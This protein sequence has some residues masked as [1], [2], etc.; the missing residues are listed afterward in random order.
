M[1][2]LLNKRNI[3]FII[4]SL[5]NQGK[6]FVLLLVYLFILTYNLNSQTYTNFYL[7]HVG[8]FTFVKNG[9][10]FKIEAIKQTHQSNY[11]DSPNYLFDN[12]STISDTNFNQ[13]LYTSANRVYSKVN[14]LVNDSELINDEVGGYDSLGRIIK[15]KTGINTLRHLYVKRPGTLNQYLLFYINPDNNLLNYCLIQY[16]VV[17]DTYTMVEKNKELDKVFTYSFDITHH[18]N[19]KDLWIVRSCNNNLYVSSLITENEIGKI[20]TFSSLGSD[21]V[22]RTLEYYNLYYLNYTKI[23]PDGKYLAF[24]TNSDIDLKNPNNR[25]NNPKFNPTIAN[26]DN[27]TGKVSNKVLLEYYYD[28]LDYDILNDV[29]DIEFSAKSH[30]FFII[31]KDFIYKY[32]YD[33]VKQGYIKDIYKFDFLRSHGTKYL[34]SFLGPDKNIYFISHN[35]IFEI[36][37]KIGVKNCELFTIKGDYNY[38]QSNK[39]NKSNLTNVIY[40]TNLY[41][42]HPF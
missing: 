21:D 40:E 3:I 9:N 6:H 15:Y 11:S 24:V 13:L 38:K 34:A 25:P 29:V 20:N 37:S 14:R 35:S 26:F 2:N 5:I 32:N 39:I 12:F 10:E 28:G 4:Q 22:S 23:S 33:E 27:N 7:S 42:F 16:N 41:L 17:L 31:N 36:G 30:S 8:S 19:G 18:K 1:G